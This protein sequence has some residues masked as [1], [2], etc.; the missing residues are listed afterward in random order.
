MEEFHALLT[1]GLS[2]A[3]VFPGVQKPIWVPA[4]PSSY[5]SRMDRLKTMMDSLSLDKR[6]E[7]PVQSHNTCSVDER[8]EEARRRTP[9]A[10]ELPLLPP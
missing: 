4:K 1:I 3:C 6:K 2:F 7:D 5:T 9:E 10:D 8:Q